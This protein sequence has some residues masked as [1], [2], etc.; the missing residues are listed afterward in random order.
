MYKKSKMVGKKSKM[1]PPKLFGAILVNFPKLFS[2][3]KSG[4]F[5]RAVK[6]K[7]TPKAPFFFFS[8][9]PSLHPTRNLQLF[10]PIFAKR[11]ATFTSKFW[12]KIP[13]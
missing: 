6:K 4:I 1:V 13:K 9:F 8:V 3:P 12:E 5:P 2:P 11:I 10:G 7:T